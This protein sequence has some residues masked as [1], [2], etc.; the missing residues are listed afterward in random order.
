MIGSKISLLLSTTLM[1]MRVLV[2]V[3]I[4]GINDYCRVVVHEVKHHSF[5]MKVWVQFLAGP[6]YYVFQ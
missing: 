4:F 2:V 3:V 6:I 5:N 1:E